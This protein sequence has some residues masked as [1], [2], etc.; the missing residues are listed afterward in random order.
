MLKSKGVRNRKIEEKEK[1]ELKKQKEIDYTQ[2]EQ[3]E[4]LIGKESMQR[5]NKGKWK[6]E[7]EMIRAEC[8]PGT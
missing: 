6:K 7:I 8:T 2:M 5:R 1:Q 3:R 4:E